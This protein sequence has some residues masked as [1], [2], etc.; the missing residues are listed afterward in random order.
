MKH[1]L[2]IEKFKTL[3]RSCCFHSF[4]SLFNQFVITFQI[5]PPPPRA[6]SHS[7]WYLLRACWR[8]SFLDVFFYSCCIVCRQKLPRALHTNSKRRI[9]YSKSTEEK[10]FSVVQYISRENWRNEIFFSHFSCVLSFVVECSAL[11]IEDEEIGKK[12]VVNAMI[13]REKSESW[14]KN[15]AIIERKYGVSGF[16]NH[17]LWCVFWCSQH[18]AHPPRSIDAVAHFEFL[19]NKWWRVS[20]ARYLKQEIICFSSILM[21]FCS[22]LPLMD[23]LGLTLSYPRRTRGAKRFCYVF[24]RFNG[25]K[26]DSLGERWWWWGTEINLS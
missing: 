23:A 9:R 7:M 12:R 26:D 24:S 11:P 16:Y 25:L 1:E 22:P 5:S 15:T 21:L 3:S 13:E 17:K 20:E 10:I 14:K 6:Q 4:D 2:K 8:V 19:I 18:K